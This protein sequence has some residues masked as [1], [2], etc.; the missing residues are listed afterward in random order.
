M[1]SYNEQWMEP[2]ELIER[3][4]IEIEKVIAGKR[5]LIERVIT[6][7]LC[8]GHVLLEDVP[9]VG[10]TTLV[11]ALAGSIGSSFKRIQFTPDQ[12]PSDI[13]GISAFHPQTMEFIY[14]PGPIMAN[15]VLADEINRA[16]PKTQ[17]ALL[18]AM[19]E[20]CVTVDGT[21]YPLPRP[22]LLLATQ[23]PLRHEGTYTLPEA[24]MDRFMFQLRV[25]YPLADQE[26][27]LMERARLSHPLE[28]VKVV[29]TG[30][31]LI[32][33]QQLVRAVH[34]DS[35]IKRYIVN[36][37]E[38]TRNHPDIR[39]GASPRASIALMRA[40]QARAWM[41]GREYVIPDDVKALAAA[42]IKHRLM[43][44]PDV[45][46]DQRGREELLETLIKH[47]SVPTFIK[48]SNLDSENTLIRKSWFQ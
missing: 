37:V 18:E 42:I 46:L 33:L 23:N 35:S 21:T 28:Q 13:T 20:R 1:S 16:S 30:D 4:I 47:V 43:M 34:V 41:Q 7:C 25:G 38:A 6:A 22:F 29:L 44:K 19:E 2:L 15:I 10:K 14:R 9:G 26:M 27:E 36:I 12:L 39:L 11:Q 3:W 5:L 31:E 48:A 17:S 40:S 24:Q 8:E 45:F 32:R